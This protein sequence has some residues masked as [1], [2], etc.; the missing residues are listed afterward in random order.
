MGAAPRLPGDSVLPLDFYQRPVEEVARDLL[1][2]HLE[3]R[4][5]GA[6]LVLRIVEVEAYLGVG[7][8][9]S[10]AWRGR[11][12]ART[13]TLFGPAG[14]AYV[15]FV[16]GMHHCLNAVTGEA[17]IGAAV[18]IRAGEP[19][20][21]R[22][23]MLA[24]RGLAGAARSW[25]PGPRRPLGE[26]SPNEGIG[27]ARWR[28]MR[29]GL[30]AGGPARLC[31]ALAVD[32]GLDGASLRGS[33]LR[34]TAGTPVVFGEVVVGPRVGVAYA[35]EAARWPLRF[36]IRGNRHVSRPPPSPARRT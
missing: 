4:L 3:R 11:P 35:G 25:Q 13:R 6:R 7:D 20:A 9:A 29:P 23:R 1:G 26:G 28:V 31:Q 10:H 18:L 24:L 5:G 21:G 32:R 30:V 15:Y 14:R 19:I 34:I 33:D 2:R 22:G 8:R 16:Y 17:G 12:T 36:A 27:A